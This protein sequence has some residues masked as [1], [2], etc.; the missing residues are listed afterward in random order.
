MVV[1]VMMP[2]GT[3]GFDLV[4]SIRA[5]EVEALRSVPIIMATA[6]QEQTDMSFYP[7]LPQGLFEPAQALDVQGWIDK[8]VRVAALVDA[9]RGLVGEQ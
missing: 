2:G 6:I 9:I 7:A 5:S 1:D 4:W 3:E 8:P